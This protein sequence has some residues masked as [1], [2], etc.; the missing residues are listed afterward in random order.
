M[1]KLLTQLCFLFLFHCENLIRFRLR[2]FIEQLLGFNPLGILCLDLKDQLSAQLL[3]EVVGRGFFGGSD[4]STV[5]FRAVDLAAASEQ[6]QCVSITEFLR[7]VPDVMLS[8]N[9]MKIACLFIQAVDDDGLLS[10]DLESMRG[11]GHYDEEVELG[12]DPDA[13]LEVS[14]GGVDD[15]LV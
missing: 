12:G 13:L 8:I 3:R 10:F 11:E 9:S 2:L 1:I 6:A 4:E 5:D 7:Y 14:S 15:I